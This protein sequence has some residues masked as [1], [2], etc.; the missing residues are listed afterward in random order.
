MKTTCVLATFALAAGF[1][2][3]AV[4]YSEQDCT[5]TAGEAVNLDN[6]YSLPNSK[7][8]RSACSLAPHSCLKCACLCPELCFRP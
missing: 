4:A 7:T 1:T 8:V 6:P 5:G 2:I 3:D